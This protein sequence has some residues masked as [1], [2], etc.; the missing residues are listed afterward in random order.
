MKICFIRLKKKCTA[1]WIHTDRSICPR[2]ADNNEKSFY[3]SHEDVDV[4]LLQKIYAIKQHIF[5][6]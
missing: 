2:R 5:I 4:E 3:A 1:A 6:N